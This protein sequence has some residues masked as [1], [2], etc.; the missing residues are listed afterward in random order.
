MNLEYGIEISK[1]TKFG[2]KIKGK[3]YLLQYPKIY[4]NISHCYLVALCFVA[5][6]EVG[7]DVQTIVKKDDLEIIKLIGSPSEIRKLKN[8]P[9]HQWYFTRL[10]TLKECYLKFLGKGLDD[11]L[12]GYDFGQVDTSR[13]SVFETNFLFKAN[14]KISYICM[15]KKN[16][17]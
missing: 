9:N 8:A 2:Y 16:S 15:Q 1:K 5:D 3:P 14:S 12:S 4:F 7:A 10:W 11:E 13:F 17:L 6:E